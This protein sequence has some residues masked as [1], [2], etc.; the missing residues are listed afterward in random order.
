M[1]GVRKSERKN[2]QR[3]LPPKP[4]PSYDEVKKKFGMENMTIEEF[5]VF[6]R[7]TSRWL[8][9]ILPQNRL[10]TISKLFV[11]IA[12]GCCDQMILKKIR[13]TPKVHIAYGQNVRDY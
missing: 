8:G 4:S 10:K 3:D 7:H 2:P 13:K 9:T 11:T 1:S 12:M 5:T 6:L